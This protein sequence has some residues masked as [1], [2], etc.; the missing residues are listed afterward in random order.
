MSK[1]DRLGSLVE[2]KDQAQTTPENSFLFE[3]KA[4]EKK[5]NKK[6]ELQRATF[7]MKKKLHFQLKMYAL[8]KGTTMHKVLEEALKEYMEK[9]PLE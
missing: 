9:Y 1:K 5:D 6:E 3:K 8:H 4:E 2:G 7:D